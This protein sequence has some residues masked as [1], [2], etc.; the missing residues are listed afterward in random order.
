MTD[1]PPVVVPYEPEFP[2]MPSA[3]S[4]VYKDAADNLIYLKKEQVQITYYTWLLLAAVYILSR[5]HPSVRAMIV[6]SAGSL[7]VGLF[8]ILFILS[9]QSSMGKFRSRMNRIYETWFTEEQRT[10]LH[11]HVGTHFFATALLSLMCG[12]AS[13]FTFGVIAKRAIVTLPIYSAVRD[14]LFR[15]APWQ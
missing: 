9:L 13:I 2:D 6:L 1:T 7:V 10:A 15:L 14:F 11:L 3:V 8:S 12:V 4:Q 5:T